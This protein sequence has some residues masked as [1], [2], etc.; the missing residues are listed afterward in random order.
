MKALIKNIRITPK[1]LNLI[2]EMIRG[3]KVGDAL[4]LLKFIPKKAAGILYKGLYSAAKNAEKNNKENMGN[5]EI[6][7]VLVGKGM[8][9]KRFQPVSRGRA[10]PIR[11]RT[12]RMEITLGQLKEKPVKE[13]S[14]TKKS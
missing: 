7:E 10:H 4:N 8:T 13:K 3:K 1:K 14:T 11:K 12:S 2:A 6:Q 5:L 9:L